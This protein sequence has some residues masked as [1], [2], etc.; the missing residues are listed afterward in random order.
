MAPEEQAHIM[1]IKALK[2]T[3][4]EKEGTMSSVSVSTFS[5]GITVAKIEADYPVG[6]NYMVEVLNCKEIHT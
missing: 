3:T 4:K 5:R 1:Q 6:Y 2:A